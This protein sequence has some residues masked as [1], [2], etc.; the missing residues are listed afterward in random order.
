M[1]TYGHCRAVIFHGFNIVRI[2]WIAA[3]TWDAYLDRRSNRKNSVFKMWFT[4]YAY[5]V[6]SQDYITQL[7]CTSLS[8]HP[9][10]FIATRLFEGHAD[11]RC[12]VSTSMCIS[13]TK[14]NAVCYLP[15]LTFSLNHIR[16]NTFSPSS[17]PA[18]PS[19]LNAS[20]LIKNAIVK[21]NL[22]VASGCADRRWK[23]YPIL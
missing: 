23:F 5:I 18:Y 17:T 2:A 8:A 16:F 21:N 9:S 6:Y 15:P 13:T 10:R 12:V 4:G 1:P 14:A 7:Q 20:F 3:S 19:N 22:N 11:H